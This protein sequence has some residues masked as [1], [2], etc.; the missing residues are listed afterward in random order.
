MRAVVCMSWVLGIFSFLLFSGCGGEVDGRIP[1]GIGRRQRTDRVI[2]SLALR[3]GLVLRDQ[4]RTIHNTMQSV[5]N[6]SARLKV[7]RDVSEAVG[8]I[9]FADFS[10]EEKE[11]MAQNFFLVYEAVA[12]GL[13]QNGA[14]ESEVGDFIVDGFRK[15]R[16]MCFSFGDENDRTDG[17]GNTARE[18]RRMARGMRLAWEN[19]AGLFEQ[20]CIRN[21]FHGHPDAARRFRER[22]LG[23]FGDRKARET[24][25][26]P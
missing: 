4:I 18:R 14:V 8:S 1:E 6:R 13:F 23:E 9:D 21:I 20:H 10:P 16:K 17:V 26:E 7:F 19:D 24:P 25:P 22:W 5:T 2:A 12:F 11:G 3:Q 15:Y